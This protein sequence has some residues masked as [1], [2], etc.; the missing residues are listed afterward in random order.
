M[1]NLTRAM[2]MGAAGASSEG[3]DSPV[4]V[5]DVFSTYVYEGNG[6]TGDGQSASVLQTINN[7]VD[8][9]GEGGLVWIKVRNTTYSHA[10][11]D[12]E[13]GNQYYISS[14]N[15]AAN[16]SAQYGNVSGFTNTGFT[17]GGGGLFNDAVSSLNYT[18][19]SFRKQKGFFDVVTYTGNGTAGRTIPHALGSAPGM[20]IVKCTSNSENWVVWH[21]S[22]PSGNFLKLNLTDSQVSNSGYFTTTAPTNTVFSLGSADEL[23]GNGRT[24]VAYVFAHDYD[25][26]GADGDESIV[27]CGTYTGNGNANGPTIDLGFEPQWVILKPISDTG[28]WQMY[29]IM[30]GWTDGSEDSLLYA[31]LSNSEDTTNTDLI[32]PFSTGFQLTANFTGNSSGVTYIYMAIARPHKQPT[33]ATQ[34]FGAMVRTGNGAIRPLNIGFP[35]DLSIHRERIAFGYNGQVWFDRVR[36]RNL[37]LKSSGYSAQQT[38]LSKQL[39]RSFDQNGVTLGNDTYGIINYNNKTYLDYFFRRASGFFDIVNYI[40]D[41]NAGRTVAHNL[42][43]VPEMMLCKNTGTGSTNWRVYHSSL[44]ADHWL[45]LNEADAKTGPSNAIWNNTVPTSESFTV[46]SDTTINAS[47]STYIAYLFATL[48]GISKVG[49]YS[50]QSGTAH[51]VDCGFTNGARFILIKRA[52]DT[53]DWYTWDY[54]RGIVSGNDP[55]S[56]WNTAATET[57]NTDYIDP[58]N[59]GFTVTASAPAA[60]NVSSGTYIFFAVA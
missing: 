48:P 31:N 53:G 13:R 17:L 29:D 33:A 27:K 16:S 4:Y 3:F 14:N 49:T 58:H 20:I 39:F 12:T 30:R 7:G 18:S 54:A 50:G 8:L 9:A 5:D 52:D 44:G 36:G 41:G 57:T 2:M 19:W 56:F 11:T 51:N 47:A 25:Y 38:G 28:Q 26:F 42:G 15:T 37:R 55:Y 35:V 34:V 24:Y 45:Q 6:T 21:R 43:S 40:G 22:L 60:L 59:A 23:N 46:A 1:S 10:L 32:K